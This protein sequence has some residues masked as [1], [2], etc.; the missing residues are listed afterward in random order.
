LIPVKKAQKT[1]KSPKNS[2]F[3]QAGLMRLSKQKYPARRSQI[4]GSIFKKAIFVTRK[5]V[6]TALGQGLAN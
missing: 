1:Q 5:T 6:R 3:I 4:A 2:R